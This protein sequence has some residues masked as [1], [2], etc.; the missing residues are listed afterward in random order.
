MDDG[1]QQNILPI[2]HS[3]DSLLRCR[4]EQMETNLHLYLTGYRGTGKSAVGVALARQTD[5]PVIDLDQVIEA[6]AGKSIRQ[7]FE[8]GGEIL[9]RNLES[10]ALFTV[11]Q[12][13]P[14]V[15]SL[16]GGT[17]LKDENREVIKRTGVCF[18]L[19][20]SAETIA[21]RIDSDAATAE[22]RPRLTS[23]DQ[24]SEIRELLQLRAD[25]YANVA[26]HKIDT[27]E[28]SVEDLATEIL[29]L[30]GNNE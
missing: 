30:L 6:N 26:D 5:R 7:I 1:K 10:E 15:I 13:D 23:L 2:K 22:N 27:E 18:W 12:S 9:F 21:Q 28:K 3:P 29:V 16:G 4:M 8:A 17:I 14:A 11:S 24:L 25:L 19:V 20:A